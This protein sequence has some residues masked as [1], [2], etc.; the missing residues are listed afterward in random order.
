MSELHVRKRNR[1]N[2]YDYGQNGA[3]FVTLCTKNHAELLC[4]IVETPA[5]GCPRVELTEYGK[6]VDK[7]IKI[8]DSRATIIDKYVIM[9]NHIHMIIVLTAAS[10]S[11]IHGGGTAGDR[12]R[13]PLQYVVRNIK[14]YATK[15]IGFSPWQKSFHDHIIHNRNE[16]QRISDYIEKNPEKW[17]NDCY[18][19]N[20]NTADPT[21]LRA[22]RVPVL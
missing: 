8:A 15:Q 11:G 1:L 13:S 21:D 6:I 10:G 18:F 5:P 17:H 16:Y 2:D 7:S 12:G 14:S 22:H 9:P 19:V 20:I 3:Y 4:H